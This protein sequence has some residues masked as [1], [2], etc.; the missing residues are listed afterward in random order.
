MK[1]KTTNKTPVT[2]EEL[3]E[4]LKDY[5]T[6]KNLDDRLSKFYNAFNAEI[7]HKFTMMR[8]DL[9]TE[10]SKFT[11]L[12]LTAIDPLLKA[13]ETRRENRE[14]GTAQIK[15]VEDDVEDLKI[16]IAKLEHS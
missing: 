1:Q 9:R 11:N 14:I 8:E 10:M 12:I 16:R 3:A 7:D 2:K 6:T 13:L 4:I 15:R 5:P